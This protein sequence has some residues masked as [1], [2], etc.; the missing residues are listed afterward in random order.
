MNKILSLL[1][2]ATITIAAIPYA[3]GLGNPEA[4]TGVAADHWI[5]MGEAAG[6]VITETSNDLRKGLRTEPN[7]VRGYFMVRRG[8]TWMPVDPTPAN[9][10]YQT[11]LTQ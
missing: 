1:L 2:L 4:P 9:T 11:Q 8:R 7:A 5:A 10:V 6:F 3:R